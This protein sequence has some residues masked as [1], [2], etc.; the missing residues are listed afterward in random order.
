MFAEYYRNLKYSDAFLKI[1]VNN[2]FRGSF[3]E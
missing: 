3:S 1:A 2:G